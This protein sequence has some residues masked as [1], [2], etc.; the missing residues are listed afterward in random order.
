M[1]SFSDNKEPLKEEVENNKSQEYKEEINEYIKII[2]KT[3]DKL[4]IDRNN[5]DKII[6][7]VI[8]TEISCF[9]TLLTDTLGYTEI[10][11]SYSSFRIILLAASILIRNINITNNLDRKATIEKLIDLKNIILSE[12]EWLNEPGNQKKL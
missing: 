7:L 8:G 3:I 11:S 5:S 12:N 10:N 9:L 1:T 4:I 2:N 6:G